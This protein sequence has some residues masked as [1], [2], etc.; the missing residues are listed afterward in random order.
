MFSSTFKF[1]EFHL[2]AKNSDKLAEVVE[3]L[4]ARREAKGLHGGVRVLHI[5][6]NADSLDLVLREF[7]D[8]DTTL[9]TGVDG[10]KLG[11]MTKHFLVDSAGSLAKTGI[12]LSGPPR[13]V[14]SMLDLLATI[15]S[16]ISNDVVG[17]SSKS[18]VDRRTSKHL[19]LHGTVL[20]DGS[21]RDRLRS[22]H[23]S[24]N[25]LAPLP[26]TVVKTRESLESSA[27]G[28]EGESLV[29]GGL[30]KRLNEE[31]GINL[32]LGKLLL[33]AV[34]DSL[35]GL[36]EGIS[37]IGRD[38]ELNSGEGRDGIVS[39]ATVHLGDAVL[40]TSH[41]KVVLEKHLNDPHS[42]I[43]TANLDIA[44]TVATLE[45]LNG[46]SVVLESR[47]LS[48]AG[49]GEAEDTIDTTSAAEGD[50]SPILRVDIDEVLCVLAEKLT[51]S[52][53]KS[54]DK[55][56]LLI[57]G[58]EELDG[59]VL[60]SLVLSNGE[61]SSHTT[62]II[63]TKSGLGSAE[64]LT[65]DVRDERVSLEVEGEISSLG[66]HHIKVS[67]KDDAREVLL[68]LSCRDGDADV[69][70]LI[71]LDG[72]AE[73][74]A[75]LLDPSG[76]LLSV[77]RGARD[78]SESKEELPES[79]ALGVLLAKLLVD[80]LLSIKVQFCHDYI[81]TMCSIQKKKVLLQHTHTTFFFF[82]QRK[83]RQTNKKKT[84]KKK[85]IRF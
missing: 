81:S 63:T 35:D 64:E 61:A 59:T 72:A 60:D 34:K 43:G 15:E 2:L 80:L 45:V 44:T 7:V 24:G 66:G 41:G 19:N 22:L 85:K 79:R 77:V 46:H 54:T 57:D 9:K 25:S 74:L 37:L 23:K 3:Q 30:S 50:L 71:S 20:L 53:T 49:H 38:G 73:L 17:E 18:L 4:D 26:D 78:L 52:Q 76:D 83:K 47:V 67:L 48:R 31:L 42:G 29:S 70:K 39:I 16:S 27:S 21:D 14:R 28:R 1:S 5:R 69:A 84:L 55:T 12:R 13:A 62:A 36:N 11:L 40:D 58:E 32:D 8:D 75:D 82:S 56:S 10:N 6:A 65:V 68:A 33:K 51:L